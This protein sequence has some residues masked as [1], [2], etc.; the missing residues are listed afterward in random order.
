MCRFFLAHAKGRSMSTPTIR[1]G[2]AATFTMDPDALALLRSL[3]PSTKR[4]GSLLSE[5]IRAE[6]S[7]RETRAEVLTALQQASAGEERYATDTHL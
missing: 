6:V 4:Y 7:R 1:R 5:L 2:K 3:A